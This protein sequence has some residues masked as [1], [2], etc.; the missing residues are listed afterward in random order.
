MEIA[1]D[2]PYLSTMSDA[3]H[4]FSG[5]LAEEYDLITL[6]YPDFEAFQRHMIEA[7][8]TR[9]PQGEVNLRATYLLQ[10][11]VGAPQHGARR[12]PDP[13]RADRRIAIRGK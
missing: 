11:S 7:I 3:T 5:S 10:V 12:Q 8:A 6:A 4:R 9:A 13:L 1:R 2:F